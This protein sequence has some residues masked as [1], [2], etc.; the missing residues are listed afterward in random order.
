MKKIISI[1]IFIC[2][3]IL[4]SCNVNEEPKIKVTDIKLVEHQEVVTE[5]SMFDESSVFVNVTFSDGTKKI[6]CDSDIAFDYQ[7]FDSTTPGMYRIKATITDIDVSF[8]IVVEV[9]E[10]V[11]KILMIGNSFSDDTVQ[12]I[13]EICDD[14]GIELTIANMYIGGCVLSTHLQNLKYDKKAYEYVSY[15][16]TTKRWSRTKNVSISE[17]IEYDDWNYISLQQGSSQ[18]GLI[19]TYKDIDEIM[20]YVLALKEDVKFVWNMTWAY[21]QDSG[22]GNFGTYKNDQMTMYNAIVDCVKGEVVPNERFDC[23]IPNGTAVQNA[24]TSFVGDNLCRDVYCHLTNEFGRYIAGLTFVYAV[25]GVDISNVKYSPNLA[26]KYVLLA[27]ESAKN[28]INN[29]FEVTESI[30]K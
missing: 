17:A 7:S 16:K 13:H 4:V 23:I 19:N 6:Y 25:T 22:H 2:L 28:A 5:G 21:Q 15:N 8:E 10:K 14:L 29:P 24:R 9:V 12:W 20:D 11:F 27:K 30:Y 26:E 3:L 1:L 18:S